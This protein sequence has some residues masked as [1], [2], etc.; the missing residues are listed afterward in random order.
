MEKEIIHIPKLSE[1][2]ETVGVPLSPVVKAGDFLYLSGLPPLDLESG[3]MLRGDIET[4]TEQVLKNIAYALDCA[5]SSLEKVVKTNVF[6]T[7]AAYFN[8]INTVYR[9]Y[10]ATSPPARTFVAMSSWPMEFDIEIE[11]V[12]LA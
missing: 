4:Q 5:G 7:N 12:A 8:V 3:K 6:V 11:C 10:F 9:R 1:I 2:L